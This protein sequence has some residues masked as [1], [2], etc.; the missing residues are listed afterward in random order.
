MKTPIIKTLTLL[1]LCLAS[2]ALL[3]AEEAAQQTVIDS[4]MVEIVT[5]GELSRIEFNGHVDA[6]GTDMTLSCDKLVFI[7]PREQ[8][9]EGTIGKM[10]GVKSIV[11][12]GAVTIT[13]ADRIAKAGRVEVIPSEGLVILSENP[14]IIDAKDPGN[15]IESWKII[16]NSKDRG[17]Q[18]LPVPLDQMQ[19]GQS[20]GRPRVVLSEQAIPKLDY[21]EALGKDSKKDAPEGDTKDAGEQD[22]AAETA[23]GSDG[24]AQ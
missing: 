16:Y 11:A 19:P 12:T 13:Q 23:T 8:G 15:F 9:S 6:R 18:F 20:G 10:S 2:P 7:T 24:Q 1:A 14:R 4:D 5:E 22:K 21:E 3:R 17:V